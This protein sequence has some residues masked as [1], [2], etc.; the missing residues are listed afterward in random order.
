MKCFCHPSKM[1]WLLVNNFEKIME[2][3]SPK[4]QKLNWAIKLLQINKM[5]TGSNSTGE[6]V[7]V[8]DIKYTETFCKF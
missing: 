6:I 1:K 4:Y 7:W 5:Y 8:N 3:T 2:K